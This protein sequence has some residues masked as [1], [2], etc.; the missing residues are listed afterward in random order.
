MTE[1]PEAAAPEAPTGPV[2]RH[3]ALET[4]YLAPEAVLYDDRSGQVLHLNG[5]AA[6]IWMTLDGE[7]TVD[8]VVAE[9]AA[10]FEVAPEAIR[11]DVD[12]ALADFA[13][14]GLLDD[15]ATA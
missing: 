6:A 1:N 9:L 2:A 14:L 15:S 13:R 12:A 3:P 5:S 4:A 11:A 7:L 10:I 8:G